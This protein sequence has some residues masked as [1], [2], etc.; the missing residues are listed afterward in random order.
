MPLYLKD[1]LVSGTGAPGSPGKSAYE[2]AK[3]G[4]YTGTEASF[5]QALKDVPGHI[6]NTENPHSVTAAQAGA[7]ASIEKGTA[8]GVAT[9][10]ED[11]LLAAAQRPKAGS[12]YR[13]DGETTV[14][15]SLADISTTLQKKVNPNLLDNWYFGNPVDQ[16]GGY[17]APPGITYFDTW[18]GPSTGTTDT[19]YTAIH[20][21]G[22]YDDQYQITVSGA[23]K[24]VPV[25]SC[26]RGY[27]GA[28]YGIDRWKMIQDTS[29]LLITNEGVKLIYDVSNWNLCQFLQ[30]VL[31][32]GITYTYSVLYKASGNNIRLVCTWGN[33]KYFYNNLSPVTDEW[34]LATVTGTIP[35]DAV[36]DYE[37]IV[38]QSLGSGAGTIDI[39]A[40][41]LE[42]GSQQTLAHQDENGNWVLNE[43]PD[44]GEELAKCKRYF[45][46]ISFGSMAIAVNANRLDLA[47]QNLDMRASP[48]V[49]LYSYVLSI[50]NT[51]GISF[52]LDAN[53]PVQRFMT[54]DGGVLVLK[55]AY[56]TPP[57]YGTC[58]RYNS[59]CIA[60]SAEL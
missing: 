47:V 4:G 53:D 41:K 52:T 26:V 24:Y 7:I 18:G 37:Q 58:Y 46:T 36:I 56:S 16:R 22:G 9:L 55:G 23:V 1:K 54:K 5:N 2:A 25:S 60:L 12:L 14:E 3:A 8:N 34:S 59:N 33:G 49:V 10:G 19:Y 32:K 21:P 40:V 42:L 57:V 6:A 38:I 51:D 45:R 15:A 30:C 39:K 17:V 20:T 29:T 43:I 50:W 44:Y 48:E 31:R 11:S 27:T 28:G 13:E 35:E